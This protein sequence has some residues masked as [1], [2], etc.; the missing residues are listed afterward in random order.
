M[1]KAIQYLG[2]ILVVVFLVSCK[3]DEVPEIIQTDGLRLTIQ[4]KSESL[5]AR[6]SV[7]F[8]VETKDGL[9]VAG[10][11]E[12][13]FNIYENRNRISVDEAARKI[14]PRAQKFGYSTLLILDLSG[15]VTNS[16]L[17]QLKDASKA[18]INSII[19]ANSDGDV[20]V[21]ISWFD[22]ED[23]LH[24]LI[25]F[26]NNKTQLITAIE[27]INKDISQ[28]NSTDLYGAVLKGIEKINNVAIQF[29]NDNLSHAAAMVIFTDGTDQAARFTKAQAT[30]AVKTANKEV[31]FYSIGLGSEIDTESLKAIGKNGFELAQNTERLIAT[32]NKIASKISDDANSYYLFE[33]CS[34]KRNGEHEV[35]IEG[36][37][38]N[39]RGNV[40]TKFNARDF[41][42]GCRL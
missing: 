21:G 6:V 33:Y 12:K 7:F 28:D 29:T 39:L 24:Q 3:K 20:K 22:G 15:S 31:T 18:F 36:T 10:M 1:M 41:T 13:D 17:P 19:P 8:K 23:K 37:Y 38:K 4:N 25:D 34:P 9:P 42:G 32:F 16:Y 35:T 30:N 40:S 5:P 27:S 14:S 11:Q 2:Y 26:T